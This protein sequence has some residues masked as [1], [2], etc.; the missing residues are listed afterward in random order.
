ML[1][2]ARTRRGT[3][4]VL[5]L[6]VVAY[7]VAWNVP[8]ARADGDA[9]RLVLVLDSSGSMAEPASG[10]GTK[11]AAA[12]SALGRV[13][14]S[15]PADQPVGL[16]VYGATVFSRGDAGACTDSQLVVPVETG[17][18][19]DLRSAI[20]SYRPYGETPIGYALQQAGQDLG[21][22]GKR[23]IVLVSDGEPTC[24]PDPCVVARNLSE[25]GIDLKIDVVGLDVDGAARE[26][27]Q[28]IA[29]AG[30]GVYYDAGSAADLAASLVKLATR[31][32]R[33]FE[34]IGRRVAGTPTADG[35]PTIDAGDWLDRIGTQKEDV[36]TYEV[37]REIPGSTLHV[38]ASVRNSSSYGEQILID[39]ATP[40]GDSC[41]TAVD[42]TQLSS[43]Q[44]IS[45][46]TSAG[47]VSSFGDVE[48]GSPCSTSDS[49]IATVTDKALDRNAEKPLEIRVYEEPPVQD[50]AALPEP[51]D[52]DRWVAPPRGRGKRTTGGSSFDDAPLLKPGSYRDSIVP[53][54]VLTYQ[55][56]ADWGQRLT[57]LVSFPPA[58]TQLAD[59]IGLGDELTNVTLFSPTRRLAASS[60]ITDG[61]SRQTFLAGNGQ[62]IAATTLPIS[63]RARGTSSSSG[64]ASI[65]GVYTV[66]VYLEED[67]DG[68]DYLVPFT[69]SLG[70]TGKV[71]G[72]PT[73]VEAPAPI[74]SPTPEPSPSSTPSDDPTTTAAVPTS[75]SDSSGGATGGSGAGLALGGAGVLALLAAAVVAVRSRRSPA[76]G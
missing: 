21:T 58:S 55:V 74:A 57:A 26:Q 10:G 54:E 53:G 28:C 43:G 65:N 40:E 9:G 27:L 17:N 20:R 13:V 66:S 37:A 41:G 16:R 31:A 75:G 22:E 15:L 1:T 62:Q 64:G 29:R 24:A 30:H 68:D 5:V 19:A 33:P 45:A 56:K 60:A 72:A 34:T 76:A 12:K 50:P 2:D 49:I 32:S 67:P 71:G 39:L 36:R 14:G 59:A 52:D 70:V 42:F 6:L 23:N 25:Q 48:E 18:R 61:P 44:L 73:Y 47:D 69:L 3:G 46:G 8:T 7:L 11:I 63:Y 4:L 35:A 51:E 38:A